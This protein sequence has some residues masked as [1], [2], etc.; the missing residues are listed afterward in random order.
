MIF[1]SIIEDFGKFSKNKVICLEL[2][3]ICI[4]QNYFKLR[5]IYS[6][7]CQDCSMVYMG[8][9]KGDIEIMLKEH[10]LGYTKLINQVWQYIFGIRDIL[11][12]KLNY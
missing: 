11:N 8:Q 6:I 5:G 9:T 4:N 3:K 1:F 10:L 7:N 12:I 2:T